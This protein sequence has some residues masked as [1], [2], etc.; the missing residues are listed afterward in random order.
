MNFLGDARADYCWRLEGSLTET[1]R[2]AWLLR[3]FCILELLHQAQSVP[4]P[5]G[6]YDL[7]TGDTVDG[8]T[9]EGQIVSAANCP[10]DHHA[11][12]LRDE[13]FNGEVR[14]ESAGI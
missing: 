1:G 8:D 3:G 5:P 2:L 6:F 13:I 10:A 14:V 11:I 4:I 12:R 7:F 9:G